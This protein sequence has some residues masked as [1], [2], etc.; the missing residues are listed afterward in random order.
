MGGFEWL[1]EP[2]GKID[3]TVCANVEEKKKYLFKNKVG[4]DNQERIFIFGYFF[5]SS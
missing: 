5:F 1:V 3:Y 2:L 4:V